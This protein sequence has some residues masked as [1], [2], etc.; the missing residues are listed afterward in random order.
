LSGLILVGAGLFSPHLLGRGTFIG[1]ADRLNTFLNVRTFSADRVRELG[2]V[3]SWDDHMFQGVG[4]CGLH[5]MWPEADPFTYLEALFPR[6]DLFRVAGFI[7][8]LLVIL[9]A[10]AFYALAYDTCAAPFPSFVG[11]TLYVLSSFSINRICQVDWAFAV[12]IGAPLGLLILR[13][14]RADNAARSF[15]GLT[16]LAAVMLLMTFL[17]EVAYVFFLFGVYACYR[18]ARARS[19]CPLLVALAALLTA[20]LFAFPRLYTVFEDVQ[21][22]DRSKSFQ[23]TNRVEVLRWFDEGLFGRFPEEARRMENGINLHE[24]VQF[25]SSI[26]AALLVVAGAVRLRRWSEALAG[27]ALFGVLGWICCGEAPYVKG[28]LALLGFVALL[29]C[30][31][32]WAL[33]RSVGH[34]ENSDLTFHLLFLAFALAVILLVQVRMLVY[35][36]FFSMDFTHS[37]ITAAAL[38]SLSLL[39]ALFLQE[40]LTREGPEEPSLRERGT[41]LAAGAVTAI[42]LL[43]LLNVL[44]DP[45]CRLFGYGNLTRLSWS[46]NLLPSEVVKSLEGLV[47]FGLLLGVYSVCGSSRVVRRWI[48]CSL[49][50]LM[51]GSAAGAAYFQIAGRHTWSFPEPFKD[52]NYF[53]TPE[54]TLQLPSLGEKRLV[55]E[56]LE[57]DKFRT[58]IVAS[59]KNYFAFVEPHLAEFWGI[60]LTGGYSA[61]V[62]QRLAALPWP[63]Q[64]RQ[65]RSLSFPSEGDLPW[66]LLALLNTKYIV[67]LDDTFYYNLELDEQGQEAARGCKIGRVLTN[68]L[69]AVPRQFFAQSVKPVPLLQDLVEG[70]QRGTPVIGGGAD[71]DR[72]AKMAVPRVWATVQSD[73]AVM[74]HWH[75]PWGKDVKFQI[76]RCAG[77]DGQFIL[78][79]TVPESGRTHLNPGLQPG[80]EYAFRI[81]AC[82]QQEASAYSEIVVVKTAC[83]GVPVPGQLKVRRTGPDEAL[84]SWEAVPD[85]ACLIEQ[86]QGTSGGFVALAT[87]AAGVSS[88]KVVGLGPGSYGFRVRASCSQGISVHSD[89]VCLPPREPRDETSLALK[90]MSLDDPCRMSLVE[91]FPTDDSQITPFDD[92]GEIRATY[93]GDRITLEVTPSEHPRFLVLNELYHPRWRA[94]A[95][96]KEVPIY[97]TNLCMRGIVVPPG[98]TAIR[99]EFTPFLHRPAALAIMAGTLVLILLVWFQ[100][101]RLSRRA[102]AAAG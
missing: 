66:G 79:G 70:A 18:S 25:H 72:G 10:W 47:L 75:Y 73:S 20:S 97:P 19:Y 87:T 99:F 14:V 46:M 91:G 30:L 22:L 96:G 55:Q 33:R 1:D 4:T 40:L 43:L 101:S 71:G 23:T 35:R 44:V 60:R 78:A 80:Q 68:P 16:A 54:A 76:E 41:L 100:F 67:V 3:P 63:S 81:R 53:M 84:V 69:P 86:A 48:A 65:L 57:S 29:G 5:W 34:P 85:V 61:G 11:A 15:L 51:L 83:G 12:L 50:F 38:P 21:S 52:N 39:I 2:R 59:P 7:S 92:R 9:A 28:T 88:Y 93:Q 13:R 36:A 90:A 77:R 58:A 95:N 31:R 98:A 24:G 56:Q 37:R 8:C 74:V 6:E 32:A 62:P 42:G 26:F 27:L 82:R 49:G 17:Q 45:L 94:F 64:V 89:P 102:M